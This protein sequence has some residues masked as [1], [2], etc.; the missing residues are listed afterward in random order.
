[1]KYRSRTE[2]AAQILEVAASGPVTKTLIMYNAFV[3]HT[4]LKEYLSALMEK[5]LIQYS[6][7]E[8]EYITT[9]KG[10]KLLKAMDKLRSM[11]S[12]RT[13]KEVYHN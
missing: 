7:T 6:S 5:G 2:I 1:M 9:K 13:T 3:S 11:I 8:N 4:Q 12:L 10:L